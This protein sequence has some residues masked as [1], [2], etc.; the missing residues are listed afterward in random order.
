M[1]GRDRWV[2]IADGAKARLFRVDD[3]ARRLDLVWEDASS[4]ARSKTSQLMTDRQGRAFDS[5]PGG[6][7]SAMEPPSDPKRREKERF[8][9]RLATRLQDGLSQQAQ[10]V[11]VASPHTLGDLRAHLPADVASRVVLE[12]A[13]DL[14]GSTPTELAEQLGDGLWPLD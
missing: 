1:A 10:L 7:R 3:R 5:G 11:L 9:T 13:K 6:R 2:L 4:A 8:A 14:T 12:L